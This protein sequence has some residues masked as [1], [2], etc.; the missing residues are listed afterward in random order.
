M[1]WSQSLFIIGSGGRPLAET[2]RIEGKKNRIVQRGKLEVDPGGDAKA[3]F[4][5]RKK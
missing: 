1:E 5:E 2:A 3:Y 4:Y